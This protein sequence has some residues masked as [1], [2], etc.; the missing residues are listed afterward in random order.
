MGKQQRLEG[1]Q[2]MLGGSPV[3]HSGGVVKSFFRNFSP[4]FH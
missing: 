3:V 4:D 2:E 1:S